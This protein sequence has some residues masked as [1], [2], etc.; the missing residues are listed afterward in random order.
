[1]KGLLGSIGNTPLVRLTRMPGPGSAEVFVK[2][3]GANPTGSMKDRMA[4]SMVEGAERRG[5]LKAA[6]TVVDYTGGSTGSS[7]AM[8][9]AA[10]GLKAR[11]VSSDAFAEEKLQTMRA[12]GATVEVIPSVNRKVTP[13]LIQKLVARARELAAQPNT[14]WTDQ[15]NNPDNRAA[16]HPMAREILAGLDGRL[17]AF[18][19][20]VGTGGAFSGNAEVLKERV[21]GVRCVALEPASSPALSGRGP[22]GGHRI[23]GIGAGFVP[24]ICRLDLADEIVAVSDDDASETARRLAQEEGILGGTSCGANVWAALRLA[25][26]LGQGRRVVTVIVDSGLKYLQ[27]DLYR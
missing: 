26:D 20:A 10:K 12:F 7:L 22:L 25:R 15:F 1:M 11:F 3:E 27:G 4:L 13:E 21:P 9:C 8:V 14:F 18:V 23:E 16:Y 17:D 5:D 19:M 2:L 24:A 6:G